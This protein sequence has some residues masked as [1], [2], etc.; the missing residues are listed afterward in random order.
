MRRREFIAL[1]GGVTATWPLATQAQRSVMPMVGYLTGGTL[2]K[3]YIAAVLQGLSD[4]GYVEG[5]N[6]AVEY[7]S[8]E[9][10]YERL[11]AL[12]AELAA[13][14]VAAILAEGGSISA[15]AAKQATSTIPIIFVNGD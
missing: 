2:N 12:A 13:R 7:R 15:R 3:S 6:I 14:Q 10:R 8:A 9:S 11:P 5:R 1:A 4:G